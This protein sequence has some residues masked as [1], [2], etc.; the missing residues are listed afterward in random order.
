MLLGIGRVMLSVNI[1][2]KRVIV[3]LDV[4]II[5]LKRSKYGFFVDW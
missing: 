2:E 1:D 3:M 4:V 5:I